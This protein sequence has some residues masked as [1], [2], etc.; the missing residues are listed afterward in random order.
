VLLNRAGKIVFANG[1]AQMM[2]RAQD[3]F[4]LKRERIEA[5]E[6]VDDSALQALIAGATSRNAPAGVPRGGAVRLARP[7][8][9]PAFNAVVGPLAGKDSWRESGPVAFVLITDPAE[10]AI[11]PDNLL[12]QLFGFSPTEVRVAERL[13]MGD[14]PEQLA[15]ALAIRISTARWHLAS[16]YR[17]TGT[18][19]QAELVRLLL[20]LPIMRQ[21]RAVNGEGAG[22]PAILRSWVDLPFGH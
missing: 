2:A 4:V 1:A 19:R 16:L 13:M 3:G 18:N 21:G 20:S 5:A 8:G 7:S 15:E 22:E 10:A 12:A 17:K 9:L 14:S 11:P 6:R